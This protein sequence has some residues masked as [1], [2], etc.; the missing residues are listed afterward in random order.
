MSPKSLLLAAALATVTARPW[1]ASPA[2]AQGTAP[3]ASPP[4]AADAPKPPAWRVALLTNGQVLRG[5]ITAED[6]VYV[7]AQKLG[8]QRIPRKRVEKVFAGMEDVYKYKRDMLPEGDVDEHLKL[9]QWCVHERLD[10]PAQEQL[11]AILD[12]QPDNRQA[13]AMLTGLEA[14]AER[15]RRADAAVVR[16]G[17]EVPAGARPGELS[18][19]VVRGSRGRN[20][21]VARGTPVIE[22]LP[23]ALAVKRFRE[24]AGFVHPELQRHCASC[25]NE[26]H[27]E[28]KFVLL[29]ARNAKQ[30][31]DPLLL[32]TN[33]DATLKLVNQ[34]NPARSEL[35]VSSILD[36]PTIG[37]PILGGRNSKPYQVFAVWVERLKVAPSA[38]GRPDAPAD[39]VRPAGFTT[40][41]APARRSGGFASDRAAAPSPTPSP[42]PAADGSPPMPRPRPAAPTL[43]TGAEVRHPSVPPD[44]DFHTVYPIG[45]SEPFA[46]P[47]VPAGK[48]VGNAPRP[49][50]PPL[51]AGNAPNGAGLPPGAARPAAPPPAPAPAPAAA[52][53]PPPPSGKAKPVKLDPSKLNDFFKNRAFR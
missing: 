42:L 19:A 4:A 24:F 25:H 22:G 5:D 16:T 47:L 39:D 23:P 27:P 36:H 46:A 12:L 15:A 6:G 37:R 43:P 41:A 38:A 45:A 18:P 48:P 20:A 13:H 34:E 10:G 26:Q 7:I 2:Q 44:A 28:S 35:L 3:V 49:V 8:E 32:R 21:E 1:C 9:A 31:N 14:S 29:Q 52:A 33:L 11:R 17:A 53:A 30:L 40:A 50:V 51:P